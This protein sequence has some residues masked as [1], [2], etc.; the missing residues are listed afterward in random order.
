MRLRIAVAPCEDCPWVGRME[1]GPG[2]LKELWASTTGRADERYFVCHRTVNYAAP[3]SARAD[4]VHG[5]AAVCAGWLEA[6][7]RNPS[8]SSPQIVQVAQRLGL[9]ETVST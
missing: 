7:E 1:L 4:A 8:V 3:P 9:V 6:V 2:R 5:A